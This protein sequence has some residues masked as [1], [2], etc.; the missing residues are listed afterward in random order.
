MKQHYGIIPPTQSSIQIRRQLQYSLDIIDKVTAIQQQ[1]QREQEFRAQV[2][3]QWKQ[4]WPKTIIWALVAFV[5][6]GI[7]GSCINW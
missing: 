3:R 1:V 2:Q 7:L 4:E 5:T 6:F